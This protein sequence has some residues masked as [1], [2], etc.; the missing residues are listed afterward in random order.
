[1]RAHR[2]VFVGPT[3]EQLEA[4]GDKLRA[5]AQAEAAGLPLLPGGPVATAAAAH[6]LAR[7]IGVPL[8]VKAVSGGGGRGMKRVDSLIELDASL[9]L[10][11]AEAGAAFGDARVYLERYLRRGRHV[12]V[13]LL[14]DGHGRAVHLGERDCSTQR[15]YQ[16]LIE[17]SPAPHLSADCAPACPRRRPLWPRLSIAAPARSS[18]CSTWSIKRSTF[19]R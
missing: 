2:I 6:A 18:F 3:P 1:M 8:L 14:G 15:R 5:R 12:E 10:A 16:K 4:V 17:E 19:W 13:Q 7:Q 11:A 9:T